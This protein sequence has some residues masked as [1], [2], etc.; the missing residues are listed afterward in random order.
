M[1]PRRLLQKLIDLRQRS[2]PFFEAL[3]VAPVCRE[4]ARATEALVASKALIGERGAL[5]RLRLSMHD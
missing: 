3:A 4:I 5:W 1:K 2:A